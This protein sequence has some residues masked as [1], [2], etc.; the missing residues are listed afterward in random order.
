[1]RR[2]QSAL[3]VLV[4]WCLIAGPAAAEPPKLRALFVTG[5]GYHDY[6]TLAPLLCRKIAERASVRFDLQWG[7]DAFADPKRAEA[8]DVLVFDYCHEE[9]GDR[10]W[11]DTAMKAVRES[12][13]PAVLIHCAVH[14][15][16]WSPEWTACCG[17]LSR[18]HDP[19]QA[20]GT[21]KADPAH[22]TLQGWPD[23][24][25]TEGDELYQTITFPET[26]HPLLRA[27]SPTDGREHVVAWWHDYGKSKIFATTL[28]H[29]IKTAGL[30][31]YQDFLTRGLLWVCGKLGDDGRPAAGYAGTGPK[32]QVVFVT[33]SD[34]YEPHV[35][36]ASLADEL[37]TKH[38]VQALHVTDR[39]Q[40]S[41]WQPKPGDRPNDIQGLGALAGA[42]LAVFF[43]RFRELPEDQVNRIAAYVDSGKAVA[44]VRTATHSFNYAAGDPL[45][46]KWNAFGKDILGAPWIYHYG[47]DSST[48]VYA[49]PADKQHPILQGVDPEF[50]VRSWL[51]HV[52]PEYPPKDATVLL[53]GKS[54]GPSDRKE[55]EDNPVAW[56]R[57]TKAGGRV[58]FTTMGH[59]ED[60]QVPAF[61]QLAINGILWAIDPNSP[62]RHQDTKDTK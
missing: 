44:G 24:W 9:I 27:K 30:Q 28:G 41:N 8:Y 22:P 43:M 5:G 32:P 36:M 50:H 31:D 4:S 56:T 54:T 55:R 14:A 11:A 29:D 40:K 46:E 60:F 57:Q 59:P 12:G 26:S 62:P 61:R 7:L 25:K 45:A 37:E 51:Y 48:D 10:T 6:E 15:I 21:T 35:T 38:G 19:F 52:K 42:D 49:G 2:N 23:D 17:M 34:E 16:R 47:H 3:G 1:M 18:A 33:G 58:F 20:F 53:M 13:K 39:V